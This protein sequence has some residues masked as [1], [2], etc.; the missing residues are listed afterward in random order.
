M[1]KI[2]HNVQVK[3][4]MDW[5]KSVAKKQNEAITKLHSHIFLNLDIPEKDRETML[6]IIDSVIRL[7]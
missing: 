5:L 2:N 4:E 1:G 7:I 6:R 3:D